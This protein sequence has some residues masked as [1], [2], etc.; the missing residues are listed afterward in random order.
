[1]IDDLWWLCQII[2]NSFRA[3]IRGL[4]VTS[5]TSGTF[6]PDHCNDYEVKHKHSVG[7]DSAD[8]EGDVRAAQL[9]GIRRSL[10]RLRVSFSAAE[11]G[12]NFVLVVI[13]DFLIEIRP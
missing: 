4:V 8:T 1:M 11:T 10:K 7:R 12:F 13:P 3:F 2:G 6:Q 5:S 9:G